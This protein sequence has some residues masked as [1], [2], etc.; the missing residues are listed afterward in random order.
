MLYPLTL[1][2]TWVH[3]MGHG[4]TALV[5]GGHFSELEINANAGG[6]AHAWAARGWPE[7]F[8]AAGGLLAPPLLGAAILASV[9]GP[10]RA[11][12]FLIVLVV[13]LF[14]SLILYVRT[15][16]GIVAMS[17][18]AVGLAWV[19]WAFREKPERRVLVA[20]FLAVILAIDTLTRMVGYAFMGRLKTGERSDVGL[21]TDN[22]GGHH[23]LWGLAITVIAL[24]TLTLGLW[25]AWRVK[26]GVSVS[27]KGR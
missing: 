24:G 11:R 17:A 8:V 27:G 22:V 18:V 15:T 9:H 14:V 23:A 10:R 1:F 7:A 20:Q 21:I 3:E 13:A 25:W 26:P 16:V 12:A 2:T 5:M 19:A 4:L 6:L